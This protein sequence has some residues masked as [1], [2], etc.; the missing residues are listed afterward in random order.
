MFEF[1]PDCDLCVAQVLIL[2]K[3]T[4]DYDGVGSKTHFMVLAISLI[5]KTPFTAIFTSFHKIEIA[6]ITFSIIDL[7]GC[8]FSSTQSRHFFSPQLSPRQALQLSD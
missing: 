8:V 4:N 2:V 3:S 5:T 6:A 7:H 1:Q